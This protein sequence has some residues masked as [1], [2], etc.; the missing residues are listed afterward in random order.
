M[1]YPEAW[2]ASTLEAAAGCDAYPVMGRENAPTPYV[3]FYRDS[4][5]DDLTLDQTF[6]SVG[7]TTATFA[8]EIHADGYLEA[9]GI[10]AA[11]RAAVRNFTGDVNGLKI[12]KAT[13]DQDRDGVPV[14]LDG[15]DTP[16]YTI[17]QVFSISWTTL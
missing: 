6:G 16:T 11:I 12:I 15:R 13:A 8:I 7:I 5:S 14:V 4:T 9:K 17:D 1:A 2:L 3:V 10:A